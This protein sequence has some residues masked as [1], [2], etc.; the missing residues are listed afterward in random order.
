MTTHILIVEDESEIADTLRYV[1][2]SEGMT[3]H[4]VSRGSAATD[5]LN[6]QKMDM[7]ILD[8]GLPDC[9][10]FELLKTLRQSNDIPVLMLTAR[11]DEVD[12]I[13][14]LEIGADD[15][16]T[17]PFSPREVVARVKAI[18]KRSANGREH[19]TSRFV[20]SVAAMRIQ[21]DG[22]PLELTRSEYRL[23]EALMQRPGQIFSRRQLIEAVWSSQ[24]PSDD[25]VIDTHV[26]S[27]R[28]KLKKIDPD[29][30]P[31]VTHRGFGYS[32]ERDQGVV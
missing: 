10:G 18:L 6:A 26:K 14:G 1:L 2:E 17:K 9:S 27:L 24:H 5:A 8:V 28:A 22:H 21:F 11:S 15:Y 3:P 30:S 20:H 19:S 13:V 25:R 23:L 16:V 7:I 29:S 12:R 31:L 32:L 4:W